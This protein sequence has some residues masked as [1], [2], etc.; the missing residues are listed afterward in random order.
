MICVLICI[1]WTVR[2]PHS[3]CFNVCLPGLASRM[4]ALF[5][6]RIPLHLTRL[7]RFIIDATLN[8]PSWLNVVHMLIPYAMV[9]SSHII[10][11]SRAPSSNFPSTARMTLFHRDSG[12]S[13]YILKEMPPTS[14][15]K[16]LVR[17]LHSSPA[18]CCFAS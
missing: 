3:M 10:S 4:P 5:E 17:I 16:N 15:K 2:L 11:C 18:L 13:I 12:G 14:Y 6:P 7:R 1:C 8:T 9:T